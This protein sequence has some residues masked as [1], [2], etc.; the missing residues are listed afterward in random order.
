MQ[1]S[2]GLGFIE[3][4]RKKQSRKKHFDTSGKSG[5][6]FHCS[7][8]CKT[9]VARPTAGASA[10]SELNTIPAPPGICCR[11]R[12]DRLPR[13]DVFS[14]RHLLKPPSQPGRSTSAF[15]AEYEGSIPFTR[16][17]ND[18]N[19]LRISNSEGIRRQKK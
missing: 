8:I 12:A 11:T 4:S 10:R 3:Q 19:R 15:Q 5:A 9:S 18:F 17:N 13:P 16:S 7:A 2:T 14:S 6:H 1:S